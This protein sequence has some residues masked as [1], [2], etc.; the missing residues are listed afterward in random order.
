MLLKRRTGKG[1]GVREFTWFSGT[2]TEV[3]ED[4]LR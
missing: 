1:T 3:S 4:F 2:P